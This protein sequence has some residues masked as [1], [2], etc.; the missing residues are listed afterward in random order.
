MSLSVNDYIKYDLYQVF[1]LNRDNFKLASLR[2]AYQRQVLIY[3]PDKF[4]ENLPEEEQKEKMDTF[5]L[6]NN[7]YTILANDSTRLEYD[8]KRDRYL[9]EEKGFGS[10]K[11]QYLADQKKKT[12]TPEEFEQKKKEATLLFQQ[13]MEAMNEEM[14][15]HSLNK[16][17]TRDEPVQINKEEDT[18]FLVSEKVKSSNNF[19]NELYNASQN[20]NIKIENN[21]TNSYKELESN[22]DDNFGNNLSPKYAFI[23]QAF[24]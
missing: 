14:S 18:K 17:E 10:L 2:K 6:I 23:D 4:P 8:E 11:S 15:K 5:L 21:G 13:Q 22:L 16:S 12:L 7:G 9:S 19:N 1:L 20:R 3:H 24:K